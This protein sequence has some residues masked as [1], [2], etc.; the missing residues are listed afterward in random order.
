[1]SQDW[2]IDVLVDLRDFAQKNDL[3]KLASQLDG[4]IHIAATELIAHARTKGAHDRNVSP[5]RISDRSRGA[6]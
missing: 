6:C 1:M 3:D 4:T 5:T 2:M